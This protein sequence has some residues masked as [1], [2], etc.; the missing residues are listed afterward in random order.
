MS[1]NENA[2]HTMGELI[3]KGKVKGSLSNSEIMEMLDETDYD[4]EQIE[5]FYEDLDSNDIEVT[6][7]G[8][9]PEFAREIENEI[10][11]YES[12][13]DMEKMLAQEGLA[14]DDPVRM[15]LKETARC[16]CFPP[17]RS[18]SLPS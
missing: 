3:E 13:K 12:A 8:P 10:E 1:N 14:I 18:W 15:Y 4:L 17:K 7:Y 11:Q 16:R 9:E 6:S 2:K 5:K